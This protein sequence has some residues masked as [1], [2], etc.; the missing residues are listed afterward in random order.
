MCCCFKKIC[1]SKARS[2]VGQW[3]KSIKQE[4]YLQEQIDALIKQKE[5]M[6]AMREYNWKKYHDLD[7]I[8]GWFDGMKAVIPLEKDSIYLQ[9]EKEDE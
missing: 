5:H 8:K 2:A 1:P 7:F 6:V 4:K 3:N 9:E